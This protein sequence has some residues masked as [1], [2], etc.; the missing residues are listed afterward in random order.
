MFFIKNLFVFFGGKSPERDVSVITGLLTLNSID[1]ELFNPIPVYVDGEGKFWTGEELKNI[2]F[3][4]AVDYSKL[5]RVYFAPGERIIRCKRG[6]KVLLLEIYCA[7]NCMH[8]KNGEDGTIA[9]LF[10]LCNAPFLSPDMFASSLSIDKD[11]SKTVMKGL[12]VKTVEYVRIKREDFFKK[13]QLF[14]SFIGKK[15]GYPLIVKP[16]RLG[17]SIGIKKVSE[18]EELFPA[19]CEAF[20]YDGKV[21]CEKFLQ[22][23]RDINC[24]VYCVNGALFVSEIE[25]AIRKD[26]ILSFAD[27][28]GGGDKTVG[29]NRIVPTDI[30]QKTVDEIKS[31]SKEIY[32]K[33]DFSSIVRFDFLL[34]DGE[35][36]L[37]E[38]N[39]VPGSLAYYFF[40]DKIGKF[41]QLLTDLIKDAVERKRKE[42]HY[43]TF[44]SSQ[45]LYG[46]YKSI[47][48]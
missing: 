3:Y 19:L 23:A 25:E 17:S 2:S 8:G 22:G 4:K 16:A 15:L 35:V 21:I 14:I 32:R 44:Y 20:N 41:T 13:S 27:K 37:N 10:R 12:N 5:F 33:L 18:E 11:F 30:C 39:A 36:Y 1:K 46:D 9:G 26:E 47:K 24:A 29:A 40:C 45:I 48:K 7:I 42:D 31:M 6:R 43:V 38:I 28:Y 34:C